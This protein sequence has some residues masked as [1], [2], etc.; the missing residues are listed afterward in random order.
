MPDN[1]NSNKR[2][3]KNTFYLYVRMA[4]VLVIYLYTSRVLLNVIG[5][6]DYGVYNVVAGFVSLFSFFNTTLASSLQRFYNFQGQIKGDAGYRNV[7]SVGFRVHLILAAVVLIILE[8][9]G[10]W[11]IN[12]VMVVPE[13]RIHVVNY[14][15]QFS[16]I[17]M[18]LVI[19]QIPYT[20]AIITNEKMDYYA[21]VSIIDV[22]L[23]LVIILLLP[24]IPYDRLWIY[25]FFQ[26]LIS[27]INFILYYFY[28]K[29]KFRYLKL[30]A[31][32]DISLLRDIISFSGWNL[33]GT[34]IF[35]MKGQGLNLMLNVFFGPIVNAARGIAFQI[36][37]ALMGFSQNISLAFKPQMVSS[38]A[39]G[40]SQRTYKLFLA[41][42]KICYCLT[43]M[44]IV[45]VILE[46]DY[47]LHLWLGKAVP[48]NTNIFSILVLVDML[49]CTLNAPVTQIVFGTGNIKCY[50][51]LSSSVNI[52]L[53]P[54]C[55]VLLYIGWQA[56]IVFFITIVFSIINQVVCLYGMHRVFDFDYED[57]V[58][59]II[60]PCLFMTVLVP[61]IPAICRLIFPDSVLRLMLIAVTSI[62][63]SLSLLYTLFL[64]NNER[65]IA[66]RMISKYCIS[67][68]ISVRGKI[69]NSV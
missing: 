1:S 32:V 41:Q 4:F 6:S 36:N 20:A 2:I 13:G 64:S 60:M 34:L 43:L 23:K 26:L 40:N 47:L 61:V 53:L 21:L 42:S 39:Q 59:K 66:K 65:Q 15:F 10:T 67:K 62:V 11:Y 27:I 18:V 14:I 45:P 17:S 68:I 12:N 54:C 46:M 25:G 3:A 9:F 63:T 16:I 5:V 56:W 37:S 48:N 44:L 50:Q 33:M 24:I 55:W 49:I 35:M 52:L 69:S 31:R 29:I 22:L 8:T 38:Y 7:Y 58:R 51:I 30:E 57:Y 19:M 28:A